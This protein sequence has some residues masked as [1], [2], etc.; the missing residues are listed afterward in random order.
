MFFPSAKGFNKKRNQTVQYFVP[1]LRQLL[2]H[3]SR[4]ILFDFYLL[5]LMRRQWIKYEKVQ[6]ILFWNYSIF[7]IKTVCL[8]CCPFN[9]ISV[10]I[11]VVLLQDMYQNNCILKTIHTFNRDSVVG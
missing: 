1:L 5:Q 10:N 6:G 2:R 3:L 9:D 7:T 11:F 8:F 4:P